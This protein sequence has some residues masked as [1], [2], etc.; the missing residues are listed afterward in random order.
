MV[1]KYVKLELNTNAHI[2]CGANL[3]PFHINEYDTYICQFSVFQCIS[4]VK[5]ILH[6]MQLL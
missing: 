4:T 2:D 3:D 1:D 5:S 6:L